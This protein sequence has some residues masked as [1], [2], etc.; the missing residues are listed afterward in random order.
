MNR[1][2]ALLS[3]CLAGCGAGLSVDLRIPAGAPTPAI[4]VPEGADCLVR[5]RRWVDGKWR[6]SY[7][8][9]RQGGALIV[10]RPDLSETFVGVRCLP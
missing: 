4:S 2:L 1:I 7:A 6:T 3:L 9:Q 5:A 10:A 8:F